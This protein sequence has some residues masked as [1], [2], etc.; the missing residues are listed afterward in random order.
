M[1]GPLSAFVQWG[2][3]L[4]WNSTA[5][6]GG[7]HT[8]RVLRKDG[9]RAARAGAAVRTFALVANPLRF[10]FRPL[11][12][13]PLLGAGTVSRV[14]VGNFLFDPDAGNGQRRFTYKGNAL[15]MVGRPRGERPTIGAVQDPLPG[16]RAYYLSPGG[17][18]RAAARQRAAP[19]ATA[20]YALARMRPGDLLVLLHGT[21]RQPIVVRRS[22]TRAEFPAHRRREPALR[23]AGEV[24]HRRPDD[25]RRRGN[26]RPAVLLDGCAHVRVAGL[27]VINAVTRGAV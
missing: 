14:Q 25:H 24:P 3:E 9:L 23:H 22:G 13:S 10:D 5:D 12:D 11:P 21:Y 2:K 6:E 27:K 4:V 19:W 16:A 26:Q 8:G 7:H 1:P 17:D 18:R 20:D 15:D